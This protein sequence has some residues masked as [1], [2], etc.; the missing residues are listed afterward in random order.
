[1]K[2][3]AARISAG[4]VCAV[5]AWG[6][7][8]YAPDVKMSA[9]RAIQTCLTVIIPSLF[10]FTAL[11]GFLSASGLLSR[12]V[13]PLSALT[14]LVFRMDSTMFSI[15]LLANISGYP[16]GAIMLKKACADGRIKKEA[17]Q[18]LLCCCFGAGP[19]F[20]CGA[21]GA[22]LFGDSLC[23]MAVYLACLAANVIV[24]VLMGI[25]FGYGCEKDNI[26]NDNNISKR[27]DYPILLVDAVSDAARSMAGICVTVTAFSVL[28]ALLY[29]CGAVPFLADILKRATGIDGFGGIINAVLEISNIS[30]M[31]KGCYKL[32]PLIAALMSF[33]GICVMFQVY[34]AVRGVIGMRAFLLCRIPATVL[35][36]ALCRP[37]MSTMGI[38]IYTAKMY[39]IGIT[40]SEISP[41]PSAFLLI[42]TI[43][44]LSKKS[45]AKT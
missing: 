31:E 1:M 26:H 42:M 9:E 37:I 7:T 18:R 21:V 16:V 3:K 19:A 8:A 13:K 44:L 40:C 38:S 24:A 29:A 41:I 28:S 30:H 20:A 22:A 5:I 27:C 34:M 32:L 11:S 33:G 45:L 17:A 25:I 10:G 6:M 12:A 14:R 36:Y 23:G 35:S 4:V 39:R 43:L 2:E 15:F